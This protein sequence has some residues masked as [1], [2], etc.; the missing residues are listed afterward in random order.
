MILQIRTKDNL[1][2][3][4]QNGNSPAWVIAEWRVKQ[5]KQVE[6]YQFDGKRVLKADFDATNS[7]RT[8]S[9]RL[10]VAFND[11]VIEESDIEWEGQNPVHYKNNNSDNIIL[12]ED[13]K[14]TNISINNLTLTPLSD[15]QKIEELFLNNDNSLPEFLKEIIEK[16]NFDYKGWVYSGS[17]EDIFDEY[18]K[19]KNNFPSLQYVSIEEI[20]SSDLSNNEKWFKLVKVISDVPAKSGGKLI[21][22]LSPSGGSD[23]CGLIFTDT[24]LIPAFTILYHFQETLNNAS[25][26]FDEFIEDYNIDY[27]SFLENNNADLNTKINSLEYTASQG[28]FGISIESNVRLLNIT[29]E[30]YDLALFGMNAAKRYC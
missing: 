20:K 3:L 25:G 16:Y 23:Y 27:V 9:D 17:Y 4:L 18:E 5:I 14:A 15:L 13:D 12:Q 1:E 2:T 22:T 7:S 6:I 26:C 10:V 8:E 28:P 19:L 29:N 24:N 11:G 30:I 21:S